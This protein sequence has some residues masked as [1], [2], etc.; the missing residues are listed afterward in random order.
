M[1]IWEYNG[2]ISKVRGDE[3]V[4]LSDNSMKE[5]VNNIIDNEIIK[6]NKEYIKTY[7]EALLQCKMFENSL[8][9]EQQ[10]MFLS[11]ERL[12]EK[13]KTIELEYIYIRGFNDA[14]A[15]K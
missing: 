13:L 15:S 3:R 8:S 14:N 9:E 2:Y 5:K 10:I 6:N 12:V 7:E 11:L 1:Y 4:G